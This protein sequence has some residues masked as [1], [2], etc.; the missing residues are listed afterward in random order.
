MISWIPAV[1]E[2]L[3]TE[4]QAQLNYSVESSDGSMIEDDLAAPQDGFHQ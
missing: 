3:P 4:K 2:T 1:Q